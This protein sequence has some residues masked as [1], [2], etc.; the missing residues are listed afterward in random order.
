MFEKILREHAERLGDRVAMR[1]KSQSKSQIVEAIRARR[2][3]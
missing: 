3:I 2:R 1:I